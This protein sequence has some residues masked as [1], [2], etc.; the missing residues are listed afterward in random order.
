MIANFLYRNPRILLLT[1]VTIVVAGGSSVIVMPRLEDPVLGRRV[2][3]VS[4]V[5]PGANAQRV[6]SLVSI[7]L[8]ERLSGISEIK[9]VRSN[10]QSGI[11]NVV[12]ELQDEVYDVESVWTIVRN[13]LADA[14]TS[15]PESCFASEL[16][17]VPLKAFAAIISVHSKANSDNKFAEVRRAARLLRAKLTGLSGTERVDTFG[18]PG[19]EY[20]VEISPTTLAETGLSTGAIAAQII[21]H[22]ANQPAGRIRDNSGDVGLQLRSDP[23]ALKRASDAAIGYGQGETRPLSEIASVRKVLVDPPSNVAIINNQPAIVLGVMVSDDRRIDQWSDRMTAALNEFSAQQSEL[24][25]VSVLFSQRA[26]V[27]HRMQSLMK[28]LGLGTAAVMVVVLLLMG[29]RSML[30]VA[31]ALPLSALMVLTAMRGLSIPIHQMSVTGLIVALGLLI[32]NAIV[33]VE[34]VRT[35]IIDGAKPSQAMAGGVRH[36]A[37]PLFGS[38]LTTALAFLPIATL[39]GPPGEFVGTIAVSVILAISASF[40]LA[41]TVIPAL[42]CLLKVNP[43]RGGILL[44]G[45]SIEPLTRLYEFSLRTV[46]RSP[47]IGVVLGVALPIAGFLAAENLPEQFFPASD[48]AQIQ[49]EVELPAQETLAATRTTVE[50]IRKIVAQSQ[51]VEQQHWFLGSSAPTFFYNVV[52]RRR[53]TPFYAQAFIDLKNANN[54]SSLVRTLQSEIDAEIREGRVIVRQLEQGPPFDAPIEVRVLGPDVATLQELGSQLRLVLGQTSNVVHTRSDLEETIPRLSLAVDDVAAQNA[55]YS[56][57]QIAGWLYTTLEGAPAG[58]IFDADEELPVRVRLELEGSLKMERLAA[59]PLPVMRRGPPDANVPAPLSLT[60]SDVTNIELESDVGA[61]VRINGQRAN[62]VKAYIQAGVLPSTVVAEFKQRL[63]QA[64]MVLPN[65]YV[66]EFGGETEQRSHAVDKLI[67]NGFILFA[68]MLLT[69]VASFQSFRCAFIV[70]AVGGL[71]VGLGPLALSVFGYPFGFMAIV[72]TMG[73][74]GVAINDSIVVLAAIR[75]D[76][77]AVRGDREQLVRVVTHSTRH[78]IA[79]TL[80]TIVGFLPLI[81]GGGGFWP[82]LAITIAGGVG[83]ATFMALYF[84]PS[85]Y[86]LL[87][88]KTFTRKDAENPATNDADLNYD[89]TN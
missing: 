73:L 17:V 46:F 47:A 75:E 51:Q 54:I 31:A 21:A 3:L 39:P 80:T 57:S 19:E 59:L 49:I 26:H 7:P 2:A 16:H 85:L 35:R 72:G 43:S 27:D 40:L 52:P 25:N 64:G 86:L 79:T 38:T 65:G 29:W 41:M 11:S 61:I 69:L 22:Q 32:D 30:V 56:R 88:L 50:S 66:L 48:R 28:N 34:D 23:D 58:T 62:E 42:M 13:R 20:L 84:V 71:S 15:L 33:I 82:P 4:T 9:Q 5:F 81:V 1:I 18:D 14:K 45:L 77:M 36:L 67:A 37:I 12:I 68:L 76:S 55:G 8:E 87:F 53:G 89:S 10:S 63:Q 6:E 74:V 44:N 78:I 70:A 83:G 60:L 24:V